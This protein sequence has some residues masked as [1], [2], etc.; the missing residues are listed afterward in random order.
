M[1]MSGEILVWGTQG[2]L[3]LGE[4]KENK[5]RNMSLSMSVETDF[6]S[7]HRVICVSAGHI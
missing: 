1:G 3:S 6:K 4:Q 7:T 5:T 2:E